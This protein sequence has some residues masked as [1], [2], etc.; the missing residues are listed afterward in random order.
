MNRPANTAW[1]KAS[2]ACAVTTIRNTQA[3]H[4]GPVRAP[5][6]AD[7][8][9]VRR[10]DKD[11]TMLPPQPWCG[12]ARSGPP[13][14]YLTTLYLVTLRMGTDE[15]PEDRGGALRI[16]EHGRVPDP[17]QQLDP[18]PRNDPVV[19]GRRGAPPVVLLAENHQQR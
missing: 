7:S 11:T 15:G 10:S 14:Q 6:S 5:R 12:R 18:G 3:G 9:A 4:A 16:L 2:T 17:G 13:S 19:G 8:P 1:L